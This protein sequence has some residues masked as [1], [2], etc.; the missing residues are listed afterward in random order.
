MSEPPAIRIITD[1]R[2][3]EYAYPGHPERPARITRSVQHLRRQDSLSIVWDEPM[4]V[5]REILLRAHTSEHL[6]RL[7]N[8]L[9]FDMDTPAYPDIAEHARRSAGGALRAL[10]SAQSNERSFVLLRPPG[11]HATRDRAMGFCYLSNVAIAVLQARAAG[12]DKVAVFDFD[13]HHGNGTEAI[14][15]DQP[16]CAF[17][18][19]H[20]FPAYPGTGRRHQR[21]CY[22]YPVAPGL[23]REA[24]RQVAEQA[25]DELRQFKPDLIA[26]SAGFDA[27]SGDPLCQQMLEHE[28][29]HWFG[30]VLR[31]LSVPLFSVLEGGYSDE[32][33]TLILAYLHGLTGLSL[34]VTSAGASFEEEP[35]SPAA[36]REIDPPWGPAF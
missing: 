7:E 9:D 5:D 30:K 25:V 16:G 1:S 15:L 14:L 8:H 31:E 24:Y 27:Y 29:F 12:V 28:D 34:D 23:S 2:C 6:D 33:P 19:V 26:V 4:T 32:L 10:K 21:N 11:H 13:V 20:Q 36:E 17:F 18:S 22:N 35:L 3:A